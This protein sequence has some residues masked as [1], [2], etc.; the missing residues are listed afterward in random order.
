M[1][2]QKNL[3]KGKA[4]QFTSGEMAVKNGRKGGKAK[5]KKIRENKTFRENATLLLSLSSDKKSIKYAKGLFPGLKKDEISPGLI[6]LVRQWEKAYKRGDTRSF[7]AFRDT[8]GEKPTD[9]VEQ[10]NTNTNYNADLD[11]STIPTETLKVIATLS[12]EQVKALLKSFQGEKEGT[13]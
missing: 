1:A 11:L 8:A 7:E 6:M 10:T 9:K 13:D 12:D 3:E 4:T 5:A 2:N